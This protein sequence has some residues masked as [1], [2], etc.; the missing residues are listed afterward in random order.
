MMYIHS[1]T[2]L[3]EIEL[4]MLGSESEISHVICAR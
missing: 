3:N 2:K 1:K 4:E